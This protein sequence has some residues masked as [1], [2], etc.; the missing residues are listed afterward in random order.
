MFIYIYPCKNYDER[1]VKDEKKNDGH[2]NVCL[3]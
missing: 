3:I 2:F 1:V